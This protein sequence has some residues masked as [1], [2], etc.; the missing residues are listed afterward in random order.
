MFGKIGAP[1]LAI[2]V[3]IVLLVFGPGKLP[4]AASSLGKAL[5]AFREGQKNVPGSAKIK[6]TATRNKTV[7]PVSKRIPKPV[8]D[9]PLP[10]EPGTSDIMASD[11]YTGEKLANEATVHAG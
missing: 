1:E 9:S 11:S 8:K 6:K 3:V 2:I 5:R 7:R 4:Q 10:S